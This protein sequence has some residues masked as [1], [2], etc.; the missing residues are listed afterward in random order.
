[1]CVLILGGYGQKPGHESHGGSTYCALASLV[2]MGALDVSDHMDTVV[3][4]LNRQNGGFQG[5]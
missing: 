2:L 5:R 4:C 3:W 1:M